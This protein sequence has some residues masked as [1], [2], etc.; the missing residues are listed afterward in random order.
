MKGH[1]SRNAEYK[2]TSLVGHGDVGEIVAYPLQYKEGKTCDPSVQQ[3]VMSAVIVITNIGILMS[4][5]SSW[6]PLV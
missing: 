5:V 2:C 3:A 1:L 4:V 6:M